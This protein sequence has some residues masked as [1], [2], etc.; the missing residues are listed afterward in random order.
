VALDE[1]TAADA[2]RTGELIEV[3]AAEE[4][5][6]AH[7]RPAPRSTALSSARTLAEAEARRADRLANDARQARTRATEARTAWHAATLRHEQECTA[8]GLPTG[9][10]ELATV[11][12][13]AADAARACEQLAGRLGE[14]A[15]RLDRHHAA[16]T[17]V[18]AGRGDA[19]PRDRGARGVAPVNPDL[20]PD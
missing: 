3:A 8:F 6:S 1:L 14:L 18:V 15:G 2:R 19:P 20:R 4:A 7:P 11:R 17:R 10:D 9:V 5:L 12:Q 13:A 16:Q